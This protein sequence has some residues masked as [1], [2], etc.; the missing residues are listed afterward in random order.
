[1]AE[2]FFFAA[3]RAAAGADSLKISQSTVAAVLTECA[4]LNPTMAKLIPTCGVLVDSTA[5]HDFDTAVD[6]HTRIDIL[7]KFAGG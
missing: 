6:D 2:V 7:P 3:A 1:M 5:C 4:A